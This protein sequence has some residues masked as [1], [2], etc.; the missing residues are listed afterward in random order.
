MRKEE[1]WKYQIVE[2]ELGTEHE[3]ENA[4]YGSGNEGDM[5]TSFY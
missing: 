3:T 2:L 1:G 4:V 5:I